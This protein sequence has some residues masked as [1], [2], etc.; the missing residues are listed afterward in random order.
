M[1]EI[2]KKIIYYN[3]IDKLKKC[4]VPQLKELCKYYKLKRSGKKQ[5]LYDRV[6]EL[7]IKNYSAKKI[8]QIWLR[9]IYN[10]YRILQ[11][12]VNIGVVNNDTDFYNLDYIKQIPQQLLYYMREDK[13]YFAFHIEGLK[14]LLL[15]NNMENPENPYTRKKIDKN[16][17]IKIQKLLNY[18]NILKY[19]IEITETITNEKMLQ[20]KLLDICQRIELLG[21]YVDIK[22]FNHLSK[23]NLVI[24]I[25]ELYDIWHYRAGLSSEMKRTICPPHGN[26]F[27]DISLNNLYPLNEMQMKKKIISILNKVININ[28]DNSNQYLAA[29]YVLQALTLVS[30]DAALNLPWLYQT[31]MG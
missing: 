23:Y 3:E 4:R 9:W 8:Q 7:F 21:F 16:D 15:K 29:C 27:I 30:P 31:V 22:W 25:K 19:N 1:K 11:N 10:Q 28:T 18:A 26:P 12:R 2:N 14:S 13:H 6:Y 5:I 24:F 20:F 17:L